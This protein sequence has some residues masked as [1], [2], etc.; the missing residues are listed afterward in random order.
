MPTV[1][2][3][4]LWREAMTNRSDEIAKLVSTVRA[5]DVEVD[6]QG[7][8]VVRSAAARKALLQLRS[9]EAAK[10]LSSAEPKD[11]AI[12]PDGRISVTAAKGE[13]VLLQ[14]ESPNPKTEIADILSGVQPND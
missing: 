4:Y 2:R 5:D 7:R 8:V 11:V 6:S 13:R 12:D 1:W 14:V 9:A 3:V 10:L